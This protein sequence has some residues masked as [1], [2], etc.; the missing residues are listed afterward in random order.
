MRYLHIP[1]HT[2][3]QKYMKP[4]SLLRSQ[5]NL[6]SQKRIEVYISVCSITSLRSDMNEIYVLCKKI[7]KM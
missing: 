5:S 6:C 7:C 1:K 2:V 4:L 3:C